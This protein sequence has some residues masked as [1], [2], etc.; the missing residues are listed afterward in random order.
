MGGIVEFAADGFELLHRTAAYVPPPY[1]KAMKMLVFPN[2]DDFTPQPWV[3]RD[4]AS[5]QRST[6][7][8]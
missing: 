3:P 2:A 7:N 5:A 6:S 1:K 4:I 8:S